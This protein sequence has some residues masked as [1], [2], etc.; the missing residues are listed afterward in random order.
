MGKTCKQKV[1]WYCSGVAFYLVHSLTSLRLA[2]S[3]HVPHLGYVG[4]TSSH[5]CPLL[6][7]TAMERPLP[8][9]TLNQLFPLRNC[10]MPH[11]NVYR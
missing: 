9:I 4:G 1:L 2:H 6:A 10:L 5:E 11:P 8:M 3:D 7:E